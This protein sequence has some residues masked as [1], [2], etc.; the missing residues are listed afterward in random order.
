[1]K[2]ASLILFLFIVVSQAISQ[3]TILEDAYK[4]K[5]KERLDDFFEYWRKDVPPISE[6]E[7]QLLSDTLK[8]VYGAFETFYQPL[9]LDKIGASEWG[10]S[11]YRNVDY[12]IV[13]NNLRLSFTKKIFYTEEEINMFLKRYIEG[14]KGIKL[15]EL[16]LKMYD[17]G[18]LKKHLDNYGL[19]YLPEDNSLLVDTITNFRPNICSEKGVVYLST[20]YNK[21]LN[22]FLGN[23]DYKV[24]EKIFS[25]PIRSKKELNRRIS[26]IEPKV[27]IWRGHWGAYWHLIT[28]PE[29]NSIIFDKDFQYA[30]ILF[31]IIYQG[32]EATLKKEDGKWKI[33]SS[34]LTWIE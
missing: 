20:R 25:S 10:D 17:K 24:N 30:K 18:K 6:K 23:S 31:R 12:L 21:V 28:F 29:V 3:I 16:Y 11:I 2:K 13:Q 26:F 15:K 7:F 33:L 32:G 34:E 19:K 27:K 4:K 14:V 9:N 1:M 22:D 8:E 5:S